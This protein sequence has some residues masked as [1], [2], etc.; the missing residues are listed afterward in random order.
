VGQIKE[1]EVEG[2]EENMVRSLLDTSFQKESH[3]EQ[4]EVSANPSLRNV[5][6]H[7]NV[8]FDNNVIKENEGPLE[9]SWMKDNGIIKIT[10]PTP[11]MLDKKDIRLLQLSSS[12]KKAKGFLK[13]ISK[14][15]KENSTTTPASFPSFHKSN[16]T[17]DVDISEPVSKEPYNNKTSEENIEKK[18]KLKL[19]AVPKQSLKDG[20]QSETSLNNVRKEKTIST[21]TY[22]RK[23]S[24]DSNKSNIR[25]KIFEIN[26]QRSQHFY[27]PQALFITNT[28]EH[29]TLIR[30]A[31]KLQIPIIGI[32]DTNGNSYGIEFPI[33]GNT[34]SIES[35][36]I[37]TQIMFYAMADG[38]KKEIFNTKAK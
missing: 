12:L 34:E 35:Q 13:Q 32:I 33:P 23:G 21:L 38:K 7:N 28:T 19:A 36:E 15:D 14:Y 30:E 17:I 25:E 5:T 29:K 3:K 22:G 26:K 10:T 11:Q 9:N 37:Y 20:M 8:T 24:S 4:V 31:V 18:L 2:A 1:R 16:V 6:F 27:I